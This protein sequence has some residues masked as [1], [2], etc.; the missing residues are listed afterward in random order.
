MWLEFANINHK[1]QFIRIPK[2]VSDRPRTQL[3]E[4]VT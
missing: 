4:L 1:K 3:G 2:E